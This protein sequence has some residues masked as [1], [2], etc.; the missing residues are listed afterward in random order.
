MDRADPLCRAYLAQEAKAAQEWVAP[1]APRKFRAPLGGAAGG[2]E[3]E[4]ALRALPPARTVL[5][6]FERRAHWKKEEALETLRGSGGDPKAFAE[7]LQKMGDYLRRGRFTG[8]YVCKL[9]Y[10]TPSMPKPDPTAEEARQ[11]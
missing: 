10:R 4:A 8:H 1:E 6:L 7:D 5:E 3:E 2:A 11:A 9:A